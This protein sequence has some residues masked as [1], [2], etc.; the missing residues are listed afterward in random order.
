MI[1]SLLE[2]DN[3]K[4]EGIQLYIETELKDQEVLN[5]LW[6]ELCEMDGTFVD[7]YYVLNQENWSDVI[8]SLPLQKQVKTITS[9]IVEDDTVQYNYFHFTQEGKLSIEETLCKTPYE[10]ERMVEYVY[11][12]FVNHTNLDCL[13]HDKLLDIYRKLVY[14]Y[15]KLRLTPDDVMKRFKSRYEFFT[16]NWSDDIDKFMVES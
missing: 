12:C 10:E 1:S 13:V 3:V 9:A 8:L 6:N 7:K 15:A 2:D 4:Y 5:K 14:K 16:V 11:D